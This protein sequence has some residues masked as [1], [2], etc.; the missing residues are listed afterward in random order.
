[1]GWR[2]VTWACPFFHYDEKGQ[3]FCEGGTRIRFGDD[4]KT[5]RRYQ[6]TYCCSLDAY[7]E[8]SIARALEQKYREEDKN[9]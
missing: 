8:C 6:D 2:N 1:M 3:S 4:V 7:R 5:L 9:G